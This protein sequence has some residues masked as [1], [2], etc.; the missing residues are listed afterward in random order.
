MKAKVVCTLAHVSSCTTW[1]YP[2]F[3]LMPFQITL[4]N[5]HLI[6]LQD[7]IK[8][9]FGAQVVEWLERMPHTQP[10]LV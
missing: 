9:A 4:G 10:T 7:C 8:S 6:H 3:V 1:E 5:F 2:Q